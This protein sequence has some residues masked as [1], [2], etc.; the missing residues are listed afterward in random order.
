MARS[1]LRYF[2]FREVANAIELVC[3]FNE[4]DEKIEVEASSV[5][6]MLYFQTRNHIRIDLFGV[7]YLPLSFL[8][9]LMTLAKDLKEKK[10]VLILAGLS[11]SVNHFIRRFSLQNIVFLQ[12]DERTRKRIPP[13][14]HSLLAKGGIPSGYLNPPKAT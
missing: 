6:A 9:K 2:R 11:P 4:V 5:F 14:M 10:R 8:T 1:K 12:S 3:L 13:T 7:K